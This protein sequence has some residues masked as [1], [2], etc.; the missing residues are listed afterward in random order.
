MEK[1]RIITDS[2]SDIDY[3]NEK[4]LDIKILPF[5]VALGDKSYT[6]RVDFDNDGFYELM[7]QYD[8]IP[9]TSQITPFEF[10]E[11]Y[12]EEAKAGYTDII[13]VLINSHGSATYGN[14][15]MAKD[16]FFEEH[17]E[18]E[19]KL[20]IYNIDG[21]G[22]SALYGEPVVNAARMIKEGSAAADI[23]AYL[24]ESIDTRRIYFGMYTLRYAGKSGRIPSAAAFVGDRLNLK[25]IMKISDNEI[26]TGAKV[27]GESKLIP[28]I[29][30]MCLADM[31]P[32]TPYEVIYGSDTHAKEEIEAM[33][34]E[35]VGYGPAGYYQ[36]GAAIA[37]NAGPKTVGL[38]FD[39]K[40][41]CQ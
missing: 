28:K 30:D 41:A 29:V 9:K 24:K 32:G 27:R 14:S 33:M 37:A 22:Y 21:K 11:L 16:L 1:I 40:D 17:P 20:N 15:L 6:S 39:L 10:Q 3:E 35:K 12:L 31:K 4:N 23:A 19:G 38:C 2:A 34:R 13:L 36:I 25:P 7:A 26:T 5:Q 18:Y 8:E